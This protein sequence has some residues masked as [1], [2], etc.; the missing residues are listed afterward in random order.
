M[1]DTRHVPLRGPTGP[2]HIVESAGRRFV[3]LDAAFVRACL[4]RVGGMAV[5]PRFVMQLQLG[6]ALIA[7]VGACTP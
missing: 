6:N 2:P 4:T 5:R 7:A 3:W 1:T